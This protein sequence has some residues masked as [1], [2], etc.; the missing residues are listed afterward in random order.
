MAKF[1]KENARDFAELILKESVDVETIENPDDFM[2]NL[3]SKRIEEVGTNK[4]NFGLNKG[5]SKIEK[6][7]KNT[8]AIDDDLKGNDLIE[9]IAKLSLSADEV[10]KLKKSTKEETEKKLKEEFNTTLQERISKIQKAKEEE[11]NDYKIKFE[12]LTQ[13]LEREETEKKILNLLASDLSSDDWN[14]GE[15]NDVKS[16]RMNLV[17]ESLSKLKTKDT[18][19]G[20]IVLDENGELKQDNL[21]NL[22]RFEDEKNRILEFTL[23]RRKGSSTPSFNATGSQLSIEA[24]KEKLDTLPKGSEEYKKVSKIYTEKLFNT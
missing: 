13:R 24:L 8:F 2:V 4:F 3:V 12:Q 1:T 16:Y 10:E 18:P 5:A 6:E 22:V 17:K 7:I 20:V 14:W 9:A 19:T 11:T 21:G 15:S 23:G